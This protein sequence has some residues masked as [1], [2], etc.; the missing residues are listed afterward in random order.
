MGDLEGL[1]ELGGRVALVTGARQGVGRAMAL[2]LA[3]AGASVAVTSRD[4]ASLGELA[5]E[6]DAIGAEHLELALELTDAASI[7]AV[8]AATTQRFGRLDVLV[9]NAG[10]SIRRAATDYTA[11]EWDEVLSTNLRAPFLLAQAA[12][13]AMTSPGGR[14]VNVS[15]TFAR[16][17]VGGRAP[18]AASKAGLEQLT[19]ALAVEWAPR[20]ITVNA[21]APGATPT[22]T[23]RAVLGTEEAVRAR[24]AEIP[25]GR[26]GTP[27][28]LVG[29]LLL[30]AGEAGSFITGQTIV[31]DGG[32]TLGVA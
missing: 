10:V 17:A 30:L 32:F 27:E 1:F 26:L 8:V 19:R 21:I 9:N 15:S 28:D 23:R 29:A 2:A 12:A 20:G 14:I 7:V 24:T 4:A 13:P 5:A 25:L 16:A 22:E 31:V 11:A 3:R 18:Y 6:L